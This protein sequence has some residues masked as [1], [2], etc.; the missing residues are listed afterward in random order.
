MTKSKNLPKMTPSQ[1]SK[2]DINGPSEI[3]IEEEY[4][5][6]QF[7]IYPNMAEGEIP[8]YKIDTQS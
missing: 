6:S 1:P 7:V 3:E 2:I 8:I 4:M 5:D